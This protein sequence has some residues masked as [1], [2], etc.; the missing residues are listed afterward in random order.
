[1][2]D[3]SSTAAVFT[4]VALAASYVLLGH[5]LRRFGVLGADDGRVALRFVVN[6][7]LP[8]LLL[9]ALTHGAPLLGPG[10]P[11]VWLTA[12]FASAFVAGIAWF[13]Y[14]RRPSYERGLLVGSACGV[15]LGTFAYPFVE[16]VWGPAG[17]RLAAL[18]DIPN[19]IVVFAVSG[20]VF[21]IEQRNT[22]RE[23]RAKT[24]KHDDGG[25][26][27]GEW[28][29]GGESKQ[30]VGVYDYPSGAAYE[31]EW[32]NNV[33][34]GYGVY[35]FAKGGS[36]AGEFRR[37]SF[38]GMGLRFM[39][40]GGVKS[41]RFEDGAFVEALGM[42]A[43]E[44]ASSKAAE[45]SRRA[46][47]AA[48]ASKVTETNAQAF[49]RIAT[50]ILTFPP[51][52]ALLLA[53][54]ATS[55]GAAADVAPGASVLPRALADAVAPLASANRP[56]ALLAMGVLFE[57]DLPR[58]RARTVAHFLATKYAAACFAAAMCVAL[59]PA[60][61]GALRFALAALVLMPVPSVCV[62]Y[63]LDHDA[64]DVTAA[65]LANYSQVLSLVA[66]CALGAASSLP[67][68]GAAAPGWVAPAALAM[69]GASVAAVGALAD[70][71]LAP[72]KMTFRGAGAKTRG[73]GGGGVVGAPQRA[74]GG[75][76]VVEEGGVGGGGRPDG[77]AGGGGARGPAAADA[78][79]GGGSDDALAR[80]GGF[81]SSFAGGAFSS[82]SASASAASLVARPSS[83]GGRDRFERAGT[84][85]KT[86]R[87]SH[88]TV[89]ATVAREA[90]PARREATVSFAGRLPRR[91]VAVGAGRGAVRSAVV[92]SFRIGV[93]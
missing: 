23:A 28:S 31:G 58:M 68:G 41:G 62:R 78:G 20:A 64:D 91:R 22:Q 19:A 34:D 46:R 4:R 14:R 43:S 24:G 66:L 93:Y 38:H 18:Y 84:R 33:K 56:L 65:C 51:T 44:D 27:A 81:F 5:L 16:A 72:V 9:H 85:A 69:S 25:V 87:R 61:L 30:G 63:A 92:E 2:A 53:C 49:A 75:G 74:E 10:V 89:R 80:G 1:M 76:V 52:L 39:R 82:A 37:G 55:G 36:Y 17:L 48:E 8:A 60:S 59:V 35:R 11:L 3:A 45:A 15:N 86:A 70:R 57:P 79:G 42:E 26:Y 6:V 88:R 67:L 13:V 21:A 83:R 32:N 7:T 29:V 54:V 73:V 40:S 47:K 12:T 50:K 90:R 71:G 77:D